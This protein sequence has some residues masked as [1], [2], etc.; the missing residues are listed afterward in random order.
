MIIRSYSELTQLES[1]DDRFAYLKLVGTV[2]RD[3]FGYDRYLNQQLYQS[4]E[5]KNIRNFVIV[6]D[7]G[8]DLGVDGYEMHGA[9]YIH[10]MNAISPAD[11]KTNSKFLLVPEFLIATTF[12][13]H[14]AI[15]YG[16]ATV[17]VN[18]IRE[19]VPNDMC[20]WRK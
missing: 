15:H 11:F 7:N 9:I 4:I 18:P 2:G 6:R 16:A 13:T 20:P 12:Q 3:T 10:H 5:W 8:C 1:F 19:R 14:N 17:P